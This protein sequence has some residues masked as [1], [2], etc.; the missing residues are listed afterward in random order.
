M[1]PIGQIN[2]ECSGAENINTTNPPSY[3]LAEITSLKLRI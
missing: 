3:R 1:H 2:K